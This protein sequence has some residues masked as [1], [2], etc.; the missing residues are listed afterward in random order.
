MVAAYVDEFSPLLSG[1]C[2]AYARVSPISPVDW[3]PLRVGRRGLKTAKKRHLEDEESLSGPSSSPST[4]GRGGDGAF[5]ELTAGHSTGDKYAAFKQHD[6][7][8]AIDRLIVGEAR[9]KGNGM[10]ASSPPA[11]APAVLSPWY[12][13]LVCALSSLARGAGGRRVERAPRTRAPICTTSGAPGSQRIRLVVCCS[14]C[15]SR[16]RR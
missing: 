2:A 4:M 5:S 15:A 7:Q 9:K 6:A 11:D 3:G 14:P 16:H 1:F 12:A 8:I 13:G 10:G